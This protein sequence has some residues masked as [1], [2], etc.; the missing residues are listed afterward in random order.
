MHAVQL[1]MCQ[2]VYM[3]EAPP[4][5]YDAARAAHIQPVLRAMVDAAFQA[6]RAL[7]G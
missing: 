4:W 6:A 5:D 7:H 3:R 2:C 1:E